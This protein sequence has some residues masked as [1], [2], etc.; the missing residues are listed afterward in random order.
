DLSS[1]LGQRVR[2]RWIAQAWEFDPT[3]SSYEE[4][5]SWVGTQGDEGWYVD[6]IR[7]TGA[8][9]AQKPPQA[10]IK[11]VA[12]GT[13][14]TKACDNTQG[15]SGFIVSTT[16]AQ[17]T[18]VGGPTPGKLCSADVDCGAGGT[19]DQFV[20]AGESLLISA[21]GTTNPGGCV[22]GGSQF[23]FFKNNVLV[24]DWSEIPT[25]TDNPSTD[26][27]YRVQVR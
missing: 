3:A 1:F 15:D 5:G 2:I 20:A 14:P 16:I 7:I 17:V 24:Q 11:P 26:A 18:C 10:D 22:G 19:C 9:N 27:N 4:V 23:R 13:C 25:F 8:L 21:T 6:D 12:N